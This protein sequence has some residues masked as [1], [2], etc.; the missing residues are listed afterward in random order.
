MRANVKRALFG[1]RSGG[2]TGVTH[3]FK[4]NV[5]GTSFSTSTEKYNLSTLAVSAGSTFTGRGLDGCYGTNRDTT[6]YTHS[7]Y[8]GSNQQ[9]CDKYLYATD[10]ISAGTNNGVIGRYVTAFGPS[11]HGMV[12][13]NVGGAA[14]MQK[15]T[16]SSDVV[17]SGGSSGAE[18][19]LAGCSANNVK[20]YWAGRYTGGAGTA[21][22]HKYTF[23]TDTAA[24]AAT[25]AATLYIPWSISS[26][27]KAY[28][29]GKS[30]NVSE[31]GVYTV[32]YSS[33]AA[34]TGTTLTQPTAAYHSSSDPYMGHHG[35]GN[36]GGNETWMY[37]F[38][39]D[40]E[41]AATNLANP[42]ARGHNAATN[43]VYGGHS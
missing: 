18:P 42:G 38:A 20:G 7:G 28:F 39:G 22:V 4:G 43:T 26:S 9:W 23:S 24:S 3:L 10:A 17:S 19:F 35:N 2:G 15:Y 32:T 33:D 14:T 5:T 6:G 21:A 30:G 11:T 34:G 27:E 25:L 12:A 1:R 29:S 36:T 13:Y 16:Y 31:K 40:I 8:Q 41:T 37:R